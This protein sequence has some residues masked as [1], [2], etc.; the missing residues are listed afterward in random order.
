MRRGMMT[1]L[2]SLLTVDI[3]TLLQLASFL[4]SVF[5]RRLGM[6]LVHAQSAYLRRM[7]VWLKV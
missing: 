3:Y 1:L 6:R 7:Q 2:Q 4:G 5:R